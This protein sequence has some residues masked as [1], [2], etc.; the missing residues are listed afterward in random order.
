MHIRS[1]FWV[2]RPKAGM[3]DAFRALMDGTLIPTMSR[4]P[5]VR[6]A[7]ALWPTS[8]EDGPPD[9]HCQILVEFDTRADVERMLGC[10]ERAALKPRV[11]EAIAMFDG[12]FS[13]IEYEVGA[14]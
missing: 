13:H 3:Q 8:R 11:L 10:A 2:G 5:G 6:Q 9:I 12:A 1:A 7:R 4:F 14:P